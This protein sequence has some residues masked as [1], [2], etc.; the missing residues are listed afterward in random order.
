MIHFVSYHIAAFLQGKNIIAKED[1]EVYTYGI[2]V[3]V[4]S[5]IGI[6]LIL[7]I[8]FL[9]GRRWEALVFL[10]FFVPIRFFCGGYHAGRYLTCNLSFIAAFLLALLFQFL[11]GGPYGL[12][13]LGPTL[14]F[15]FCSFS[16]YAPVDRAHKPLNK[17]EKA[18]NRKISLLLV[19]IE[20]CA[21]IILAFFLPEL[22]IMA[23][24][25]LLEV[26]ILVIIG[27]MKRK[28]EVNP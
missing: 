2:E 24:L 6:L 18:R 8:G 4:S 19:V 12:P 21:V 7:G 27:D 10:L 26:A 1:E 25:T 14:L 17:E 20:I 11:L 16:L 22:A 23:A 28:K 13:C 9:L 3:L 5:L 15:I